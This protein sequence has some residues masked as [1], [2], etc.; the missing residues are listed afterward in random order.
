MISSSQFGKLR[1]AQFRPNDE[2]VEL[3]D[4]EYMDAVWVGE[5]IGFSEWLRLEEEPEQLRSL[6]I[7]F[8]EFPEAIASAVLQAIDLP[9]RS[10]MRSEE[11]IAVLGKPL[12]EQRFVKDRVSYEFALAEP[13]R[14]D[15][16]CTV[17]NE[18]GLCYVVV[19]RPPFGGPG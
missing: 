5:A 18:G 17:L 8:S 11:L 13:Q 7:D 6:A 16:S 15:V 3:T 9:I 12:E 14:Y 2:I 1:L 4:W 19:M 10:G